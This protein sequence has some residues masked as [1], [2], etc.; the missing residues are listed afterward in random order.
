MRLLSAATASS[1]FDE[2]HLGH[3]IGGGDAGR[4]TICT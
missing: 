1:S 3:S 4:G 2:M